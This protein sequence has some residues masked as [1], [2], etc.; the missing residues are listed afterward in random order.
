MIEIGFGGDTS[1]GDAH[2]MK[3]SPALKER[4]RDSPETFF[5]GVAPL[6]KSCDEVVLNL[7]SVLSV[8]PVS[9]WDGKKRFLGWDTPAQTIRALKSINVSKVSLANNHTMDFGWPVLVETMAHLQKAD[10]MF[11][12]AGKSL[13]EACAPHVLKSVGCRGGN[14][15]LFS[16]MQVQ[17]KLRDEFLFYAESRRPGVAPASAENLALCIAGVRAADPRSLIVVTPHWGENYR[18]VSKPMQRLE[19][20]LYAAGANII[21]GHGAHMLQQMRA[22]GGGCTIYSLGNFVFN[23]AGRFEKYGAPPFGL[24]VRLMVDQSDSGWEGELKAYPIRS[25]NKSTGYTPVPVSDHEFSTIDSILNDRAVDG[26]FAKNFSS[27]VD[28]LGWHYCCEISVN[29]S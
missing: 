21:I 27:A 17:R 22:E 5:S 1:L 24:V 25:D 9:P 10:I 19:R 7:E 23:W 8:S 11:M 6:L 13:I 3:A 20:A 12:G 16:G 26:T 18:W 2:L 29:S 4:L 28:E 14:I 15:Y